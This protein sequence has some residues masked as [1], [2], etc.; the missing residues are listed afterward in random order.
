MCD[1]ALPHSLTEAEFAACK[2]ADANS[3]EHFDGRA[4]A[5]EAFNLGYQRGKAER[6]KY[7]LCRNCGLRRLCGEDWQLNKES[8]F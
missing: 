8:P 6:E 7:E 5:N 2:L 4:L 3:K 1:S